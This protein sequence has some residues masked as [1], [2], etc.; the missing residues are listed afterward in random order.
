MQT[1]QSMIR[2]HVAQSNFYDDNHNSTLENLYEL[3]STVKSL[4][5]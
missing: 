3:P 4:E 2:T 1:A 5:S